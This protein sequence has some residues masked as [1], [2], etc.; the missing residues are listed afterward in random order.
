MSSGWELK[1]GYR[2]AWRS[3]K[4]EREKQKQ[5]ERYIDGSNSV[6]HI[7]VSLAVPNKEASAK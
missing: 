7:N 6:N 4:R 2:T 5:R 1:L 3:P